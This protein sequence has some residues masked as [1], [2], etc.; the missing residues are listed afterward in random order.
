MT[1]RHAADALA[2]EPTPERVRKSRDRY[3]PPQISRTTNRRAGHIK[4]I[5]RALD[6]YLT[7]D[8]IRAGEKLEMHMIGAVHRGLAYGSGRYI[9][10]EESRTE[11]AVT[12]HNQERERARRTVGTRAFD[13]LEQM[14]NAQFNETGH[15]ATSPEDIG[16][17][18]LG[19][20]QR[21]Q[22]HIAGIAYI[23]IHLGLLVTMWGIG[24]CGRNR[25]SEP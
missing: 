25:T 16:R 12:R 4:S 1:N 5:W 17:A 19:C 15:L 23:K 7:D 9:D 20:R 14:V 18:W 22:A 24:K 3:V 21:G 13:A 2:I 10:D 8:E 6:K 11:F